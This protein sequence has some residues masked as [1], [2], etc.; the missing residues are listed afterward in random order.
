MRRLVRHRPSPAMIVAMIALFVALSGASYAALARNSVGPKQLKR[1]AVTPPKIKK[2]AVTRAKI[3]PNAIN[4]SRVQNGS[5]R[6]VDFGAGQLPAGPAGA[7]GP[8]GTAV[9][10]AR[11]GADGTLDPGTPPQNKN[12]VQANVEHDGTTGEG[13]YCFGGLG[14]TPTSGMVTVDSAM[15]VLTSNQ[16]AALAIQRGNELGSCD[17]NHQQA[18]VSLLRVNDSAPP[19]LVDHGFYIW[20]EGQ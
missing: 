14:F 5:L 19:G 4:S 8:A 3:R 18:R 13:I 10:Y 17:A 6:A 1:S 16:I 12:V 20:F 11:V 7:T 2:K 15:A 9:A